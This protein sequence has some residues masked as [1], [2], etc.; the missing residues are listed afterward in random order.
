MGKMKFEISEFRQRGYSC[1]HC[2][3][4]TQQYGEGEEL[5][6]CSC[7][8]TPFNPA[9]YPLVK[10]WDHWIETRKTIMDYTDKGQSI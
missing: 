1:A 9:T 6:L 10:I 4:V 3:Q 2:D 7:G 8:P 5:A